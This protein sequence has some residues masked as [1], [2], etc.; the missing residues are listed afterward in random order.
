MLSLA[1]TLALLPSPCV[2]LS[3][4]SLMLTL[5]SVKRFISSLVAQ[6]LVTALCQTLSAKSC[7]EPTQAQ[8]SMATLYGLTISTHTASTWK[9]YH[10]IVCWDC[11]RLCYGGPTGIV[12]GVSPNVEGFQCI[13]NGMPQKGTTISFR[14]P[15]FI[16]DLLR[17]GLANTHFCFR[18]FSTYACRPFSVIPLEAF[19][20]RFCLVLHRFF[21]LS[22]RA[23]DV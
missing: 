23:S 7:L 13:P 11:K 15:P 20:I 16:I 8:S 21:F 14:H 17:A 2:L 9:N 3:R 1:V 5:S 4:E 19:A 18:I 12:G 10:V 22:K 6:I